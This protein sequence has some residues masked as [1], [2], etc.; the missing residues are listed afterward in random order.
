MWV[1]PC[2]WLR[3]SLRDVR[4][5]WQRNLG[6]DDRCLAAHG[7]EARHPFLAEDVIAAIGKLPFAVIMGSAD[8][9]NGT[10]GRREDKWLLRQVARQMGLTRCAQFKKVSERQTGT[11]MG[12]MVHL[13]LSLS[14]CVCVCQRAIQFG[15][16][17][18]KETNRSHFESN[19]KADGSHAYR[20]TSISG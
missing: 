3:L 1:C 16:R 19:R 9:T 8:H 20:P 4:R 6:R 7:R 11:G 15:S 17:S 18:A 13:H 2:V 12:D 14:A 10:G 5:L